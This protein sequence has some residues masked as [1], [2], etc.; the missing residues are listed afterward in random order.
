MEI[1]HLHL[2]P[3]SLCEKS[4]PSAKVFIENV[5]R[6]YI[7][8]DAFD[9]TNIIIE[10]FSI[11]NLPEIR[12]MKQM[13]DKRKKNRILGNFFQNFCKYHQ[14]HSNHGSL[15]DNTIKNSSS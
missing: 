3:S 14:I 4:R 7:E 13:T 12:C 11:V 5:D 6:L 1:K 9:A 2:M 8:D 10:Y 15:V